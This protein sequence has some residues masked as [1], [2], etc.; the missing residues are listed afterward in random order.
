MINILLPLAFLLIS[1][2][3]IPASPPSGRYS[4]ELPCASCSAIDY[5]IEFRTDSTYLEQMIYRDHEASVFIRYGSYNIDNKGIIIL[6]KEPDA[7]M[8]LF[9]RGG[10]HLRILD[11]AGNAIEGE[12]A[13]KYILRKERKVSDKEKGRY[14]KAH[15]VEPFWSLALFPA[16]H[17]TFSIIDGRG[18]DIEIPI[19]YI[20]F[21]EKGKDLSYRIEYPEGIIRIWIGTETCSDTMSDILYPMKIR[22]H[23]EDENGDRMYD[24][25]AFIQAQGEEGL[26]YER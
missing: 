4:A 11:I 9:D 10:R 8:N 13:E 3:S 18:R 15:G 26:Y 12:L 19:P 16:R 24:G 5:E 2:S 22:L 7:G 1:C 21:P 20:P 14:L 23:I 17:L 25:C 6:D